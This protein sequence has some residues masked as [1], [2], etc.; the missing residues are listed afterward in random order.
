MY[1]TTIIRGHSGPRRV[2]DPSVG[3]ERVDGSATAEMPLLL[4]T[5]QASHLLSISKTTLYGLVWGGEIETVHVG[6]AVRYPRASL[7]AYVAR[8]VER[9]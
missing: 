1:H 5:E 9:G 4:T 7:E 3:G 8:L 2:P 6:R